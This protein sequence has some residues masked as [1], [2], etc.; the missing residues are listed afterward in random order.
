[1][2]VAPLLEKI[3][4]NIEEF[5]K[6]DIKFK[7]IRIEKNGNIKEHMS[8]KNFKYTEIINEQWEDSELRNMFAEQ[9]Y[10]FVVF[11][12]DENNI[13]RLDKVK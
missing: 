1:M 6:A 8:F 3:N 7:T 9:K 13:L 4:K 10:L 5:N 11:R 2:E 12:F